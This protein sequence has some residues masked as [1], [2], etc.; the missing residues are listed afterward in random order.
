MLNIQE[1]RKP[2]SVSLID[3]CE[4]RKSE[5]VQQKAENYSESAKL[6]KDKES[7][8]KIQYPEGGPDYYQNINI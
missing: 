7:F 1:N 8:R 6:P 5:C 3:V 2:G 4:V